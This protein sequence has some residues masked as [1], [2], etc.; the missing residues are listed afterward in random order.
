MA[1]EELQLLRL[2]R[3]FAKVKDRQKRQE[4]VE[5]IEAAAEEEAEP[6]CKPAS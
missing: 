5:L 6:E 4:F 2:V 1:L 3:A